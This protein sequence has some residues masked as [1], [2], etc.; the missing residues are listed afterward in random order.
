[1]PYVADVIAKTPRIF[2]TL[3]NAIVAVGSFAHLPLPLLALCNRL[4]ADAQA[5]GLDIKQLPI[6]GPLGAALAARVPFFAVETASVADGQGR[7]PYYRHH[8]SGTLMIRTLLSC[9]SRASRCARSKLE[10]R[11]RS[12]PRHPMLAVNRQRR[13][14]GY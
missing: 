7:T 3:L 10:T 11:S 4:A 8:P 1:M 2:A 12:L 6:A 5:R 9:R 13:N 14:A